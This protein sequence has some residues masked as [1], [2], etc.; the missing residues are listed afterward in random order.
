MI[1]YLVGG[2]LAAI[3]I[4]G[5]TD[6]SGKTQST[7]NVTDIGKVRAVVALTLS[8]LIGEFSICD[9]DAVIGDGNGDGVR[10][11]V[12]GAVIDHK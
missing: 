11:A 7:L 1:R 3:A 8:T 12:G 5:D 4:V 9:I 6:V 10:C 2:Q